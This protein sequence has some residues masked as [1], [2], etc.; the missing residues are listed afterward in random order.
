MNE[1]LT[2]YAAALSG[3]DMDTL[4]DIITNKYRKFLKFFSLVRDHTE[5]IKKLER[6]VK[7][8]EKKQKQSL[9]TKAEA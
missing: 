8:Q 4:D 3:S 9:L 7:S 6:R 1:S 2:D 5:D